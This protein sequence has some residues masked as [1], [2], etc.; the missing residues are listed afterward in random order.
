MSIPVCVRPNLRWGLERLDA[1]QRIESLLKMAARDAWTWGDLFGLVM[2]G[3][4]ENRLNEL[5]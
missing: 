5:H 1:V 3:H 4:A 2:T